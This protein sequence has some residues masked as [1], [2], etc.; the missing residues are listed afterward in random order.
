MELLSAKNLA[1]IDTGELVEIIHSHDKKN[2]LAEHL[3]TV[4]KSLAGRKHKGNL[5]SSVGE[6]KEL[7][8]DDF[9]AT[10]LL[11]ECFGV[12]TGPAISLDTRKI[13]IAIN[14]VEWEEYGESK[15]SIN[16]IDVKA[17]KIRKSLQSWIKPEDAISLHSLMSHMAKMLTGKGNTRQVGRVK[18][19]VKKKFGAAD[20]IEIIRM[21]DAI[22]A[23]YNNKPA[24]RKRPAEP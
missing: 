18:A 4:C 1:S 19:M 23:Q 8:I 3:Q 2:N 22:V 24:S 7:K 14:L 6:L 9:V 17:A 10:T 20:K 13:A 16:M 12:Y 5:P 11:Q 21:I 15:E